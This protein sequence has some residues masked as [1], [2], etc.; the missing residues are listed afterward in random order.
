[1]N[2][3]RETKYSFVALEIENVLTTKQKIIQLY[4]MIISNK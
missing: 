3:G 2:N 1:M 4:N